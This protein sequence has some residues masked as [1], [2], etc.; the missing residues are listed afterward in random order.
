MY[1]LNLVTCISFEV[2]SVDNIYFSC[3]YWYFNFTGF[4]KICLEKDN[5]LHILG[6]TLK[7][8]LGFLEIRLF[9]IKTLQKSSVLLPNE[10]KPEWS[11]EWTSYSVKLIPFQDRYCSIH[12]L[13][14]VVLYFIKLYS[15]T[16]NVWKIMYIHTYIHRA[17][18]FTI[19]IKIDIWQIYRLD[20]Y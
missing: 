19:H 10:F 17:H 6:I 9:Y 13:N 15:Y 8:V 4:L 5:I 16:L 7:F 3:N 2:L 11:S 18:R 12:I 1:I 20:C 14:D